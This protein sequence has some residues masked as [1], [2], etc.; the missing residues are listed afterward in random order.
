MAKKLF[1]G[2]DGG[3]S[4]SRLQIEDEDGNV[5]GHAVSG[6]SSIRISVNIA[7]QSIND[8]LEQA[9]EEAGID[10]HSD[11]YELYAGMG[12]AGCEIKE[13]VQEFLSHPHPFKKLVLNSDGYCC[14]LGAHECKDGAII[15]IGTG[16]VG[17]QI[18][19]RDVHETS[20][21]G[22]PQGDEGAGA[23]IGLEAQRYTARWLDGRGD[24]SPMLEAI[25]E[26]F[27]NDW[28]KFAF[29]SDA[30]N[31]TQFATLVPIVVKYLDQKDP[32]ALKLIKRSAEEVEL[33]YR[34]LKEKA[35]DKADRV[36]YCLF[37]GVAPFI[38][39]WVSDELK[40]R[41]VE[42]EHDA[43]K[44]AIFMIRREVLGRPLP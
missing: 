1:I 25:F 41:L 34:T 44:G 20:G 28:D 27:D 5:L 19:G 43:T 29:W 18:I 15:I 16:I 9:A 12:L 14:C 37:G 17:W 11:E 26:H 42:R 31:A 22:F 36:H 8:A 30:A 7:W 24:K 33:I 21:W 3:G 6:M 13:K 4:K 35:A 39:P 2:V 38:Q 32:I 10:I 23:W 40:S